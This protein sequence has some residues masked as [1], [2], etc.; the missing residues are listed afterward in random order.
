MIAEYSTAL[1]ML[2]VVIYV[3]SYAAMQLG[4]VKGQSYTYSILNTAAP[5]LVLLS[6]MDQFNRV[7]PVNPLF[8]ERKDWR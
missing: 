7:R 3:G 2:G 8:S 1:G 6:L 4:F 5:A